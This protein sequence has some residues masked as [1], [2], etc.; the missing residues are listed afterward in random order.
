QTSSTIVKYDTLGQPLEVYKKID[1]SQ[2]DIQSSNVHIPASGY[3]KEISL[4]YDSAL[5]VVRGRSPRSGVGEA[6]VWNDEGTLVIGS[7]IHAQ[8]DNFYYTS[9]EEYTNVSKIGSGSRLGSYFLSDHGFSPSD[10]TNLVMT[11]WYYENLE[12]KFSGELD[13]ANKIHDVNYID[14]LRVYPKGAQVTTYFY[15][16]YDRLTH[17]TDPKNRTTSYSYDD[18][19]R[20]EFV[21][22]NE[23]HVLSAQEYHYKNP[24]SN[25]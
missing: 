6:Y 21:K 8:T 11:Y 20:L 13:F 16:D 17:V 15:D 18:F 25:Q 7:A 14:E 22:D 9:F 10:T 24:I 1:H 12:W 19:G 4:T 23:G 5:H 3:T 2:N